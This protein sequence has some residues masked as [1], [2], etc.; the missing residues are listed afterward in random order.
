MIYKKYLKAKYKKVYVKIKYGYES[1]NCGHKMLL[2][3]SSDYYSNCKKFNS[4]ADKLSKIDVETPSFRF[5]I[6]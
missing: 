4:I 6:N 1:Y 2:N 5:K 3:I